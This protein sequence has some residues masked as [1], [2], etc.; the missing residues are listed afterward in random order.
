MRLYSAQAHRCP[1]GRI[2]KDEPAGQRK[3]RAE[4]ANPGLL[5]L[6]LDSLPLA[7]VEL[8]GD[9]Q[10][11]RWA[12]QAERMF[13]WTA[14]EVIGH[15]IDE[16]AVIHPED[17]DTVAARLGELIA[18]GVSA[19][20]KIVNRN[21]TR[22]GRVLTCEWLN[23]AQF[24]AQGRLLSVLS[25]AS[26][27]SAQVESE[28]NTRQLAR[29]LESTLQ[30]IS[31]A[32]L[33]VDRNWNVTFLNHQA[34]TLLKLDRDALM[35]RNIW[36]A[37]PAARETEFFKRGHEAMEE[38]HTVRYEAFYPE[39]LNVWLHVA[40]Y[41]T[42]EGLAVYF[43][44]QT[45]RHRARLE[46]AEQ[47]ERTRAVLESASDAI[48]TLNGNGLIESVNPAAERI[49]GYRPEELIGQNVSKLMPEDHAGKHDNH[50]KRYVE[51]GQ[52]RILDRPQKL[53]ARRKD[54]SEFPI[55]LTVTEISLAGRQ[56]FTG[57]V[58]DITRDEQALEILRTSEERFRA[59]ARATTDVVWD[60]DLLSNQ[61]WWSDGL[62]A[63]F[64]YPPE[65]ASEELDWWLQRIHPDDRDATRLSLV[66]A[67]AER[68]PD[69]NAKYRFRRSDGSYAD[70][71]DSGY[72]IV[73]ST[74]EPRRMVGGLKDVTE[75]RLAQR[76][77]AEQ[78]ELLDHVRD[79]II[80][81]DLDHCVSYWNKGAERI[82]GWN[83]E[84][85]VGQPVT[86]LLDPDA[87][88]YP[89]AFR[90]VLAKG[91]LERQW[92][93][94]RKDGTE[95]NVRSHWGLVTDST[96][97][98][99][100]VMSINTDISGQLE[101]EAQL[102]Q[103]QRLEAIGQLT[104]GVAHD[105]N[106]LLTVILGNSEL[107][108]E[109]LADD[110][111]F[112]TLADLTQAAAR[113]GAELTN[114]LLAFARRQALEPEST[115][116]VS[117]IKDMQPLLL[118]S[119]PESIEI[120]TIHAPDLWHAEI[121]PTQLESALLN[122]ALN[123]RD[124]MPHGG[125][126]TIETANLSVDEDYA[127]N[128]ADLM[129][130]DYVL[131]MVSD[132]G[133]GIPAAL[134]DRLFEPFFTTKAKGKGTG[135]GLAMVYG[136]VKQSSGHVK[137][138][139]EVGEGT[140]V[141]IFL[142]RSLRE[143]IR[144]E[145][146]GQAPRALGG[147]E[148]ILVVE[149]DELVREHAQRLLRHLGYEVDTAINGDQALALLEQGKTFELLF[150]DVIMPGK[151]NGPALVKEALRIRPGLK[152]LYTSGYTEN[153]IVHHGRLDKGVLL[154]SKP[155]RRLDLARKVREALEG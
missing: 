22:D 108:S 79:A 154:L 83:S 52:A 123:A 5:D 94:R 6:H 101:L 103:A 113:R 95:I 12:A 63:I 46:A 112:K 111:D 91:R 133:E 124:A 87:E 15:P 93:H 119:M 81:I 102:R 56:V 25:F 100:S 143:G 28:A 35:G 132:T 126:L 54:G 47:L 144:P 74:G 146:T 110:A 14:D 10:V 139:S 145:S 86:D 84:E 150:T 8:D 24:D 60:H 131:I 66:T 99:R 55:Q 50:V 97:E 130:G 57:F 41:P 117:L 59:V 121:D 75:S 61:V 155:Y 62:Q 128:Q 53:K 27:I 65:E 37:F 114:R 42:D 13:G 48:V 85:A 36:E 26:D 45:E 7:V 148:R 109:H 92:R 11:I 30:S 2:L 80:V 115:D 152:V 23:S 125:R 76:K 142:P 149:D 67:I 32:F 4:S 38:Q 43:S 141:R 70:V 31:D 106:N 29:R 34:E 89:A 3:I 127:D 140:T 68:R 21:I 16:V 118:R 136:F 9:G 134:M 147:S 73:D 64:G 44:D 120:R 1:R 107:L 137:V 39:P 69:W 78:A 72:L 20:L 98:P 138:Y 19:S 18:G 82:Y 105:F 104:G 153:A 33:T 77:L 58:Q 96:G 90:Q 151:L 51:T 135:L 122:L 129:P 17:R 116:I 40:A 88:L 71:S 49:F